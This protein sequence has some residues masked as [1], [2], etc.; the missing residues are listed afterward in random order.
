MSMRFNRFM[1]G[2]DHFTYITNDFY[3]AFPIFDAH[4]DTW[5]RP[6]VQ[7]WKIKGKRQ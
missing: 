2:I 6:A 4:K 5:M 7:A 1:C 3:K